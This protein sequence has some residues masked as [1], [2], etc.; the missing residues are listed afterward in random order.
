MT[1]HVIP[2][3]AAVTWTYGAMA[4]ATAAAAGAFAVQGGPFSEWIGAAG[5]VSAV[6]ALTTSVGFLFRPDSLP[7]GLGVIASGLL[8]LLWGIGLQGLALVGVVVSIV[9]GVSVLGSGLRT[10]SLAVAFVLLNVLLWQCSRR[11][12]IAAGG[13]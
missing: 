12:V 9:R 2:G 10:T 5:V 11:M 6:L 1:V 3:S 7:V 4:V 13:G 8:M